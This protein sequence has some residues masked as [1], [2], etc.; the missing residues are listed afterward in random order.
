MM[1]LLV[2]AA[3]AVGFFAVVMANMLRREG[4]PSEAR[5]RSRTAIMAKTR[6]R[7]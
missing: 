6:I 1:G 5:G 2:T 3:L 4:G 7:S